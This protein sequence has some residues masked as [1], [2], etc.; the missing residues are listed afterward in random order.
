M[1]GGFRAVYSCL[2]QPVHLLCKW[3]AVE[4]LDSVWVLGVARW[5][6]GF[7]TPAARAGMSHR[8]RVV[9]CFFAGGRVWCVAMATEGGE[10]KLDDAIT[11]F[12]AVAAAIHALHTPSTLSVLE[13]VETSVASWIR[14]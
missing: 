4:Q 3:C 13:V 12:P 1:T 7:A 14:G 5:L 10:R 9:L 2:K 8:V 11:T 6:P